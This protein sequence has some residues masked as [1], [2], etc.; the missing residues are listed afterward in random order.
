MDIRRR[1]TH[2]FGDKEAAAALCFKTTLNAGSIPFWTC[3]PGF[4]M[5]SSTSSGEESQFIKWKMK[6]PSL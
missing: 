1:Q 4:M 3:V 6:S 2:K 5:I